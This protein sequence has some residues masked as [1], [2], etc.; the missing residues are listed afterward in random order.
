MNHLNELIL[1]A[2]DFKND[3]SFLSGCLVFELLTI[4]PQLWNDKGRPTFKPNF[5]KIYKS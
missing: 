1:G 4:A 5:K 2:Q 3:L